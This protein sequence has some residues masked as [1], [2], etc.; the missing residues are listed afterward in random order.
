M[1]GFGL[2]TMLPALSILY[3]GIIPVLYDLGN[4][5]GGGYVGLVEPDGE[6][7]LKRGWFSIFSSC[8]KLR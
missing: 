8:K 2:G 6:K 5:W 1:V 7:A 4:G 3:V